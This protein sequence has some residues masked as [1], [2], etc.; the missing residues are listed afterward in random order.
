MGM[1]GV[2]GCGD[3]RSPPDAARSGTFIAD[4]PIS[5]HLQPPPVFSV[6]AANPLERNMSMDVIT[7]R[8]RV[9]DRS[10]CHFGVIAATDGQ[11]KEQNRREVRKK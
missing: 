1:V 5:D 3:E 4:H 7:P 9:D 10:L 11:L 6:L 2:T 8:A